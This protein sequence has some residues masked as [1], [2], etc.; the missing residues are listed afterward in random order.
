M[1]VR[2]QVRVG[3]AGAPSARDPGGSALLGSGAWPTFV[4][5]SLSSTRALERFRNQVSPLEK[6]MRA[7][8]S[9]VYAHLIC[10]CESR[11][12]LAFAGYGV[13]GPQIFGLSAVAAPLS[14]ASLAGL[15]LSYR[16]AGSSYIM[17]S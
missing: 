8:T 1:G 10:T 13:T 17:W 12:V 11:L 5:P 6:E 3:V 9:C 2:V 4:H 14:S 16:A 15:N 7:A